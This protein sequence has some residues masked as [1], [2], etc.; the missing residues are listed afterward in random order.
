MV[1]GPEKIESINAIK[2][3]TAA[4][5]SKVF[6]LL[7]SML[8]APSRKQVSVNLNKISYVSKPNSV[9]VI[10]GKVL[11]SGELAHKV[12]IVALSF[13]DSAKKKIK[14]SGGAMHDYAWLVKRGAKDIILVK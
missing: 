10:A 11:G 12:D 14:A 13:S 4:K 6:K 5:G 1:Y 9:V 3:L 8:K 2:T 7:A